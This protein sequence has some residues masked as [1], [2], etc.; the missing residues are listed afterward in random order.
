MPAS[1]TIAL[2]ASSPNVTGS[3]MLI[4][5]NGPMPGK[6]PTSVPTRQP[7]KPYHSTSGRSATENP[8]IRLSRVS[9]AAKSQNALFERRFEHDGE[10]PVG[11]E[12]DADAVHRG[13]DKVPA[14]ERDQGKQQQGHRDDEAKRGVKRDGRG[15]DGEH[16]DCMGQVAPADV[17]KRRARAAARHQGRAEQDHQG[18]DEL[19]HHAGARKRKRSERQIA[20]HRQYGKRRRNGGAAGDMVSA[21]RHGLADDLTLRPFRSNGSRPRPA[22][23]RRPRR[24]GTLPDRG[25][26]HPGRCSPSAPGIWASSLRPA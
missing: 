14:F 19:W 12:A 6:T 5:D 26:R 11:E 4:P 7:R 10:K 23:H 3:R 16:P 9:T 20:A 24:H 21:R 8:S 1:I 17:G 15:R 2:V 18:T 25:T 22:W 13:G